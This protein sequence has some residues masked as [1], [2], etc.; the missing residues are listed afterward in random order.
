[1]SVAEF[2]TYLLGR[3]PTRQLGLQL[4]EVYDELQLRRAGIA[5]SR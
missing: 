4:V 2:F 1:M 3:E 5:R